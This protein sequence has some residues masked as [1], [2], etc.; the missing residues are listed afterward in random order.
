MRGFRR[1]R[2][3]YDCDTDRELAG[4]E[5]EKKAGPVHHAPHSAIQPHDEL[6]SENG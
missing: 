5:A 6:V 1:G 4:D 3:E 2:E